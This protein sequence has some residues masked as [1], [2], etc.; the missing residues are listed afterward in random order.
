MANTVAVCNDNT[1]VASPSAKRIHSFVIA[2]E[3]RI[4]AARDNEFNSA[5]N[6]LAAGRLVEAVRALER[7]AQLARE[8]LTGSQL[9]VVE[10]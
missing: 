5:G 6:L 1:M 2:R 9:A 3:E 10:A 8:T 4:R 7:C